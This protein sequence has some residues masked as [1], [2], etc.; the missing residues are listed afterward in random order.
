MTFWMINQSLKL[1]IC[2]YRNFHS[3][4]S[5]ILEE[6]IAA[7]DQLCVVMCQGMMALRL[8][9]MIRRFS[10]Y[11]KS[12][13]NFFILG[14]IMAHKGRYPGLHR[15]MFVVNLKKWVELGKQQDWLMQIRIT[16]TFLTVHELCTVYDYAWENNIAVESCNF[17]YKPECLRISVLPK[18]QRQYSRNRLKQWILNHPTKEYQQILNTR[19]PNL[20]RIQ[21]CQDAESYLNY[22]DT[23]EDESNRL[24]ELVA[25]L[26][27]LEGNRG[28][29]I[30]DY[31]PEYEELF[32]SAG[33]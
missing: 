11:Y 30:L 26:K 16:P 1:S 20:A 17:L 9:E 32:R 28:N 8:A 33:Y 7:G 4:V 3:T 14:H 19:D 2:G 24:P 31:I 27:R 18:A 21:I 22:L 12:N 25:Y 13:P 5:E 23:A 6:S 29:C 10:E 15:Q